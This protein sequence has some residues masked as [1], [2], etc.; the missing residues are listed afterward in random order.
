VCGRFT[1]RTPAAALTER[2]SVDVPLELAPRYNVAPT[3]PVAAF[4]YDP[5]E[6]QRRFVQLRWGLVPSWA[7]DPSIGARM[8][9]ARAET[10]HEK[11]AFRTAFRRRRCLV[12]ADGYFEWQKTGRTKQPYYIHFADG[13]PFALAALWERWGAPESADAVESC[14][15]I[16][17]R[18][19]P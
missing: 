1:L 2:F 15:I 17:T 4:R 12:L 8:I 13:R 7:Q 5:A 9:N 3:Q 16:T 10:V 19:T 6:H 18:P 11:P 14:A